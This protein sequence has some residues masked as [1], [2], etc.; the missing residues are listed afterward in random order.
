MALTENSTATSSN[1]AGLPR[2]QSTNN[3]LDFVNLASSNIQEAFGKQKKKRTVNVRKF[4]QKRVRQDV[5]RL[6]DKKPS[7]SGITKTKSVSKS[8]TKPDA[9]LLL[10]QVGS[11]SWPQ[12]TTNSMDIQMPSQTMT[13][14]STCVPQFSLS[15][16]ESSLYP[17][18]NKKA[19][20]I[21]PELESI[22]SEFN[23]ESVDNT[24]S[25]TRRSSECIS[26]SVCVSPCFTPP[27]PT[28]EMQVCVAEYPYSPYSDSS[29]E[30]YD[31]SA[32]SSPVGSVSYRSNV[33]SPS[34]PSMDN[35]DWLGQ[36]PSTSC[37]M[38]APPLQ[39]DWVQTV[40]SS[41]GEWV[42]LYSTPV[43]SIDQG[44]PMTPTVSQLLLENYF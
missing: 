14:Y 17:Q 28:L 32:Y 9:K 38:P 26:R 19:A 34:V 31:D 22:L 41:S 20:A 18:T 44:L 43:T 33:C 12:L 21:D 7:T 3:L 30:I 11:H 39:C 5:K 29:E 25:S 36:S 13:T 16:S 4:I 2:A 23:F 6:S 1:N 8:V 35:I 40:T 10:S 37:H 27:Q 24:P 42:P 15:S